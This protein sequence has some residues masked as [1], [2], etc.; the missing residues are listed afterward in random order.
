MKPM[1]FLQLIPALLLALSAAR[2]DESIS[3]GTSEVKLPPPEEVKQ[4]EAVPTTIRLVG[5]DESRQ[6][7]ITGV[8]RSGA[9][10]D[11]TGDVK[12]EVSDPKVVA[13]TSAGRVIPLANGTAAITARYGDKTVTINV[14]A[15]SQDVDLP[16]NFGNHIVPIFTKLGCNGG[17]CHGKSG[18]QNGFA[19]SLLGFVPELDYQTLVKENRGRRLL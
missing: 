15:E 18:G 12:Y 7:I 9:L 17:G 6:L 10:Q 19:L 13:V 8:L 11:Y 3:K 2:A 1:I 16:I 4:L 5:A 14:T